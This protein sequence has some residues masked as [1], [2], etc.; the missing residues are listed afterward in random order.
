MDALSSEV[1]LWMLRRGVDKFMPKGELGLQ[2]CKDRIKTVLRIVTK[3]SQVGVF[4]TLGRVVSHSR[5]EMTDHEN[6]LVYLRGRLEKLAKNPPTALNWLDF[7]T[8]FQAALQVSAQRRPTRKDAADRSLINSRRKC[9]RR[10]RRTAA[11]RCSTTSAWTRR[12]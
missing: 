8:G 1:V 10:S 12:C 11:R 7:A 4:R 3:Y 2:L 6:E 5:A 9:G